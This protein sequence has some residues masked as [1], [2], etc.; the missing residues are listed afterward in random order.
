MRKCKSANVRKTKMNAI[1][2]AKINICE[3]ANFRKTKIII[4]K[5]KIENL[6]MRKYENATTRKW[7]MQN[8]KVGRFRNIKNT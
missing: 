5:I 2:N 7:E 8:C 6:K 4:N 1:K 3:N